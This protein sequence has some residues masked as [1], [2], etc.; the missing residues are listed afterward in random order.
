MLKRNSTGFSRGRSRY[1]GVTRALIGG[2]IGL[3]IFH[4]PMTFRHQ[5]WARQVT[6]SR[7]SSR[8]ALAALLGVV[9]CTWAPSRQ[10]KKLQ[11]REYCWYTRL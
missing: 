4:K 8:H 9:T 10:R 3:R 7:A 6:I 1:R 5:S 2:I 11:Q